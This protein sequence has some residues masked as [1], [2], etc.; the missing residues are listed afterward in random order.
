MGNEMHAWHAGTSQTWQYSLLN[1]ETA[2]I[3]ATQQIHFQY[4]NIP[5]SHHSPFSTSFKCAIPSSPE[6][7]F[8]SSSSAGTTL[9]LF[10]TH[11]FCSDVFSH[12][13][14]RHLFSVKTGVSPLSCAS[15]KLRRGLRVCGRWARGR[16]SRSEKA[17]LDG[18]ETCGRGG[19]GECR[20]N[21]ADVEA[22]E[23]KICFPGY[24]DDHNEC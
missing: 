13:C 19:G 7:S 6:S 10:L 3:A 14:L 11:S 2:R 15:V 9:L 18:A 17:Q 1:I 5:V 4:H 16:R 20:G 12:P 22:V 21:E 8:F 24:F 23:D